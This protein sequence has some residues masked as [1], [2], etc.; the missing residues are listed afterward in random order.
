MLSKLV[1]FAVDAAL[2][3]TVLAGIR[4][5]SGYTLN[6]SMINNGDIKKAVD[7]WLSL[8]EIIMDHSSE[9][10]RGSSLFDDKARK[11]DNIIKS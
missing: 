4:R 3:S 2:V 5:T 11:D 6:T 8:G 9:F 1:H 10:V 7:S